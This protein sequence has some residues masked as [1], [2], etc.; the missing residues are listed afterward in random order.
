MSENVNEELAR[1]LREAAESVAGMDEDEALA[2]LDARLKRAHASGEARHRLSLSRARGTLAVALGTGA[3]HDLI[4]SLEQMVASIEEASPPEP[5][6]FR[7]L[8]EVSD[9]DSPHYDPELAVELADLLQCHHE[10]AI[11]ILRAI[12]QLSSTGNN[13][14][15]VTKLEGF[16]N[17][18]LEAISELEAR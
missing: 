8:A 5:M 10:N 18:D 17:A 15:L 9:A 11:D 13:P 4:A 14:E 1:R 12:A 7:P 2:F 6:T 3:E 16:L